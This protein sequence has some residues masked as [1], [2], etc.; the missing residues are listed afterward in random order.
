[1]KT[2]KFFACALA[3]AAVFTGC[4]KGDE[5]DN[6]EGVQPTAIT[7]SQAELTVEEGQTAN[8]AVA[9]TPSDA[10]GTLTW[11]S[12][13]DAVATVTQEGIVTGVAEG[14]ATIVVTCGSL[15]DQCEVTVTPASTIDT[16]ALLNGSNYYVFSIDQ[17][18]FGELGSKVTKDFRTNGSYNDD[19]T[20]PDG[21]TS[22]LEIWGNTFEAVTTVPDGPNS[23]GLVEGW[24]GLAAAAG[25]D[26][27]GNGC[28]GI[29]QIRDVD[30]TKLTDDHVLVITYKCPSSNGNGNTVK[31]TLYSTVGG[32]AEW[33]YS[34]D[35]NTNGEW[36][37]VEI[38]V[39]Q[40]KANGVD[41][42]QPFV[43]GQT[44]KPDGSEHAMYTLG[45]LIEGPNVV[46]AQLHV[47][48]A[49][50]YKPAE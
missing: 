1:M 20:I 35:A 49:F 25:G 38:P 3:V 10:T 31:F 14:T 11:A 2:Y 46:G 47:D 21:V 18:T 19:G 40:I 13:D 6:P 28:G 37:K 17:T 24:I 9:F 27:S 42:S 23:F 44:T 29:R 39:S 48:A 26:W 15:T 45:L 34:C 32:G 43:Y 41:W 12:S 22:I 30:F 5:P 16:E 36:T 7:L 33:A 4:N 8:L 50:I